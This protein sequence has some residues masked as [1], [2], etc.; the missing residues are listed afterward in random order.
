MGDNARSSRW[1]ISFTG[2]AWLKSLVLVLSWNFTQDK[3]WKI[4]SWT[5]SSWTDFHGETYVIKLASEHMR[6]YLHFCLTDH[7]TF[8]V[9]FCIVSPL[10]Q[11]RELKLNLPQGFCFTITRLWTRTPVQSQIKPVSNQPPR[12]T[13]GRRSCS[14]LSFRPEGS[15]GPS[16][17][18]PLVSDATRENSMTSWAVP[19]LTCVCRFCMCVF[20][21]SVCEIYLHFAVTVHR[22]S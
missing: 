7:L 3:I 5:K 10:P 17:S 16:A 4:C 9:T 1:Q 11:G 14:R 21:V 6:S 8:T 18:S 15:L 12:W 13:G 19:E 20:T 2:W 22:H